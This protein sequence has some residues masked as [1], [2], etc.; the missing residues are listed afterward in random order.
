MKSQ[1]LCTENISLS[2]ILEFATNKIILN[3][4]WTFCGNHFVHVEQEN[5]AKNIFQLR[6]YRTA[7]SI[8][9]SRSRTEQ[10]YEIG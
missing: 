8:K 2:L 6:H 1:K 3:K 7:D 10:F 4:Q 9:L 5:I